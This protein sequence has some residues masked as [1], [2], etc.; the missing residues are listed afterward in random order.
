MIEPFQ[1]MGDSSFVGLMLRLYACVLF[2]EVIPALKQ[3]AD[4]GFEL[5]KKPIIC[6]IANLL[7]YMLKQPM[8]NN[9]M[10]SRTSWRKQGVGMA[11]LIWKLLEVLCCFAPP[12]SIASLQTMFPAKLRN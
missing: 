3:I 2:P 6:S 5:K 1:N 8:N 12:E 10:W 11:V 4:E 7:P 9:L